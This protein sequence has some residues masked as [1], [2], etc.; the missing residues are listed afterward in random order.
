[1]ILAEDNGSPNTFSHFIT[2]EVPPRDSTISPPIKLSEEIATATIHV[3]RMKKG[4]TLDLMSG[5]RS[6]N[7]TAQIDP[8][9]SESDSVSKRKGKRYQRKRQAYTRPGQAEHQ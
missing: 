3:A 7:T 2:H 4:L 1:M 6:G 8:P 9:Q 5:E